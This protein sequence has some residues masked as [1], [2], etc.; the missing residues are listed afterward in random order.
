[1]TLEAS[2]P[3]IGRTVGDLDLGVEIRAIRRRGLKAKIT[4]AEAGALQA[5]DVV[6]L[7]GAPEALAAAEERLTVR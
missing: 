1:V 4:A 7:L 6:V 5:G 3:A 2:S